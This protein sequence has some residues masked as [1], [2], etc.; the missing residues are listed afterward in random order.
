M[1]VRIS[2]RYSIVFYLH[3]T[4]ENS[5][6]TCK[7]KIIFQTSTDYCVP[8]WFSGV[9]YKDEIIHRFLFSPAPLWPALPRSY[10]AVPAPGDMVLVPVMQLR[11]LGSRGRI[12]PWQLV[13]C[14]CCT[15]SV[16]GS[17]LFD[18]NYIRLN[19]GWM[20]FACVF[21]WTLPVQSLELWR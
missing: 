10:S 4:P 7:R 13:S 1:F 19:S 8:C 17:F 9:Y 20:L 12:Q 18:S 2:L 15:M 14:G 21:S 16:V 11:Y 5:H 3:Y 6:G